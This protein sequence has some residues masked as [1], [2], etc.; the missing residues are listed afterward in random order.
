MKEGDVLLT[1]LRQLDGA[2]KTS[3]GTLSGKNATL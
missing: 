2:Q 3:S 1:N